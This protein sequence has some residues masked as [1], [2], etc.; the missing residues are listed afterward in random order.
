MDNIDIHGV[1][2]DAEV[3]NQD[4]DD[5]DLYG[6]RTVEDDTETDILFE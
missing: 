5:V 2:I 4:I 1:D 3:A 6:E